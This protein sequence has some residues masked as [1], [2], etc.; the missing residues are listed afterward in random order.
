MRVGHLQ[1]LDSRFYLVILLQFSSPIYA[2]S[3]NAGDVTLQLPYV[4][5]DK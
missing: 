4:R 2:D 3:P 5:G 1:A